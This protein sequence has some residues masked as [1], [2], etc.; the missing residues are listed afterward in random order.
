MLAES[1][2][3]NCG[4]QNIWLVEPCVSMP[5][6]HIS[7]IS[8]IGQL[9]FNR[10]INSYFCSISF[11]VLPS[12]KIA[13]ICRLY[14]KLLSFPCATLVQLCYASRENCSRQSFSYGYWARRRRRTPAFDEL[15][16]FLCY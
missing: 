10:L 14:L 1:S 13:H 5:H 15:D 6:S 4:T 9:E 11:N 2:K 3:I 8:I 7:L 12:P 16:E